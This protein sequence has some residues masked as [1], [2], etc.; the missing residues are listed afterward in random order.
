MIDKPTNH[1]TYVGAEFR[2]RS[3]NYDRTVRMVGQIPMAE[4]QNFFSPVYFAEGLK[5]RLIQ[6]VHLPMAQTNNG[7]KWSSTLNCQTFSREVIRYLNLNFPSDM[8]VSS[9]C[10]PSVINIYLS[11]RFTT[12]QVNGQTNE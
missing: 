10:L 11:A 12:A 9:D 7:T 2:E 5:Q 4:I 3:W 8:P 1:Y 6:H